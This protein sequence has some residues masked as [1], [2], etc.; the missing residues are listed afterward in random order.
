MFRLLKSYIDKK[1]LNYSFKFR[2]LGRNIF[3]TGVKQQFLKKRVKANT[4]YS[5][6]IKQHPTTNLPLAFQKS[7][8]LA[9]DRA[10][11]EKENETDII[12][13]SSRSSS[14]SRKSNRDESNESANKSLNQKN[15]KHKKKN[16]N[17]KK[18]EK[19]T[20]QKVNINYF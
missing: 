20:S 19:N 8:S 4:Y 13:A 6:F 10:N 14:S 2:L 3:D 12:N 11:E 15:K 16:K 5:R 18:K 17:K 1:Y 9:E 7:V